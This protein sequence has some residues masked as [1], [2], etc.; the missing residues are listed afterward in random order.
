[1]KSLLAVSTVYIKKRPES[2]VKF[3][4]I[5]IKVHQIESFTASHKS[6][7][8]TMPNSATDIYFGNLWDFEGLKS[9]FKIRFN[10]I[11]P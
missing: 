4:R 6:N 10:R 3:Y 11:S 7:G 1:M 2:P 5:T 9:D 8:I